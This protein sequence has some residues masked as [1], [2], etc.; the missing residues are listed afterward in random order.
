VLGVVLLSNLGHVS[1]PWLRALTVLF[2]AIVVATLVAPAWT[3]RHSPLV[4][5]FVSLLCL[6]LVICPVMSVAFGRVVAQAGTRALPAYVVTIVG[7]A[8]LVGLV[9]GWW[10]PGEATVLAGLAGV[11]LAL[12]GTLV[13]SGHWWWPTLSGSALVFFGAAALA[14]SLPAV[15][16]VGLGP[17]LV[18]GGLVA[19]NGLLIG[20]ALVLGLSGWA[21]GGHV[22]STATDLVTTGRIAAGLGFVTVVAMVTFVSAIS[23]TAISGTATSGTSISDS[24]DLSDPSLVSTS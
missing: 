24:S 3:L 19:F 6:V 22:P 18:V 9:V 14:A 11:G 20:K 7:L 4:L 21:L 1:L 17:A 8:A 5:P 12:A 16:A 2:S 13:M 15:Y 23:G 10:R